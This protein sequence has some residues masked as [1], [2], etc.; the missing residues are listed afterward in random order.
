MVH[1]N[2][3]EIG[4]KLVLCCSFLLVRLCFQLPINQQAVVYKKSHVAVQGGQSLDKA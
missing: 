4:V 3:S 1:L 2:Y